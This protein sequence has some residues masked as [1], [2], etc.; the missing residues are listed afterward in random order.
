MR[1]YVS[2]DLKQGAVLHPY[3]KLDWIVLN[4]GGLEEQEAELA[5]GNLH[6]KNWQDEA[7]N[8][9]EDLVSTQ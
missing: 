1:L 2:I 5:K 6:A 9:L 3:F 4:W 8:V 7:R